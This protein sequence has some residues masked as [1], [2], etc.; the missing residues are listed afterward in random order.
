MI[1]VQEKLL[2]WFDRKRSIDV[3][4][5]YI[6]DNDKPEKIMEHDNGKRFTSKTFRRF[7]QRNKIKDKP[8]PSR[9]PQL[10]GKIEAY[11]KIVNNEFLKVE[12]ILNIEDE[13]RMYFMFVKAYNEERRTWWN[14]WSHTI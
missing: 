4:E 11:N 14:Q 10:Q 9:Y 1:T 13:K 7:L 2:D 3:L 12:N 5:G 6:I 8:I